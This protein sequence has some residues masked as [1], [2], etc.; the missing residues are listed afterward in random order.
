[1]PRRA[2]TA[3]NA[4]QPPRA[5]PLGIIGREDDRTATAR[6]VYGL[7]DTDIHNW[8]PQT[9]NGAGTATGSLW[10]TPHL[11]TLQPYEVLPIVLT[12]CTCESPDAEM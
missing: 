6:H 4:S 9:G 10:K 5:R 7:L 2:A 1:M 3:T 11:P 12:I 8:S